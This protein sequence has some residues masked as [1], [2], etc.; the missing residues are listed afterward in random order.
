M[1]VAIGPLT[2][3]GPAVMARAVSAARVR[4][5]TTATHLLMGM[6]MGTIVMVISGIDTG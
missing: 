6:E 5:I 2:D 1:E 3:G 4:G